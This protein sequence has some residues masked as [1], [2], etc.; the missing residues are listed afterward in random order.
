VRGQ[1]DPATVSA[2]DVVGYVEFDAAGRQVRRL[3]LVT[4]RRRFENVDLG[5]AVRSVPQE[6]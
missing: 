5:V 3:R 1:R 4:D 6:K 2:A